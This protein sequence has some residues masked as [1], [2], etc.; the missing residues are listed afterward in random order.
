MNRVEL[1]VARGAVLAALLGITMAMIP[2]IA[3][4]AKIP[5]F[6]VELS[7]AQPRAGQAVRIIVRFWEDAGQTKPAT[8]L[9]ENLPA[10]NGLIRAYPAAAYRSRSMCGGC[11]P[12]G[13]HHEAPATYVGEFAFP[14]DGS[15]FL[16]AFPNMAR[17]N[18]SE[19]YPDIEVDVAGPP[20]EEGAGEGPLAAPGKAPAGRGAGSLIPTTLGIALLLGGLGFFLRRSR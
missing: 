9:D 5:A 8:W 1:R 17:D 13:L 12:I 3:A 7:P 18:V 15:W 19:A 2:A 14:Q 20:V 11:F 10:L 4:W 16:I 6:S